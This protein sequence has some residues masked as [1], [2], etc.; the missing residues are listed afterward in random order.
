MNY[1]SAFVY[2]MKPESIL[3][4]KSSYPT[5]LVLEDDKL[6]D[7]TFV[8]IP[9]DLYSKEA[10]N[11]KCLFLGA[12]HEVNKSLLKEDEVLR[13]FK[14]L[15]IKK[16]VSVGDLGL[17]DGFG[18]VQMLVLDI[19]ED[20]I[21]V[22]PTSVNLFKN[23]DL[24]INLFKLSENPE[25]EIEYTY[26]TTIAIDCDI[27]PNTKIASRNLTYF[28]MKETLI[29]IMFNVYS[30]VDNVN[31]VLLNPCDTMRMIGATLGVKSVK[32]SDDLHILSDKKDS[33][34]IVNPKNNFNVIDVVDFS[35]GST[36]HNKI[37]V[38]TL[39]DLHKNIVNHSSLNPYEIYQLFNRRYF[40]YNGM[41]DINIKYNPLNGEE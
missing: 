14:N 20:R 24:P 30:L 27:F 41:L 33:Q 4:V 26:N 39:V 38:F 1:Y 17:V 21:V 3:M 7:A 2:R 34:I 6:C 12:F 9:E 32:S 40:N 18:S 5:I 35:R 37:D 13:M 19:Y 15:N 36:V 11:I 10:Y 16:E 28:L 8:F 22:V 29:K 25:K 31:L 23:I